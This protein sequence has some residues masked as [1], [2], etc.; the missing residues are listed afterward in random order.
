MNVNVK[1][2]IY[3]SYVTKVISY[4]VCMVKKMYVSFWTHIYMY[5]FFKTYVCK[6]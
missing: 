3:S 2:S 1:T 5:E 6:F 4:I